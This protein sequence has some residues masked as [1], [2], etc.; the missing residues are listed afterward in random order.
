M[1]TYLSQ[2]IR[3]C[4]DYWQHHCRRGRV[5]NQHRE[6]ARDAHEPHQDKGLIVAD[7]LKGKTLNFSI[8]SQCTDVREKAGAKLREL[9]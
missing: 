8:L 7:S 9:A 6:D 1:F 4:L 2:R 5:R 3:N